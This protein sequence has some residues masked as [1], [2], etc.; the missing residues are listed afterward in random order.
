M[1]IRRTG[2]ATLWS[3]RSQAL[4]NSGQQQKF[5]DAKETTLPR[6]CR[7]CDVRFACNG[8]CPKHRFL[9]TP[10]GEPGLNY[11]CAGYK[12]FFHHVDPYMRFMAGELAAERAPANVMR[13]VEAKDALVAFKQA[14]RNDSCPCGSIKKFK[15]CCGRGA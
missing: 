11:L 13:W 15:N 8:E 9:T 6:Y 4:V 1:S 7:E 2:W 10:D 14:G 5:G 12:I 3:R